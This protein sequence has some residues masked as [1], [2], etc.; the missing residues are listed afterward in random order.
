MMSK[1]TEG[2][3]VSGWNGGKTGPTCPSH[4]PTVSKKWNYLP[5]GV[6]LETLAIVVQQEGPSGHARMEAN[7]HLIAAAPEMYE[8]LEF[9]QSLIAKAA[10]S[11]NLTEELFLSNAKTHSL[12]TKARGES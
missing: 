8:H 4:E 5:V 9:I 10:A 7:A 1:F 11:G 3:W 12:L 2:E 6:G